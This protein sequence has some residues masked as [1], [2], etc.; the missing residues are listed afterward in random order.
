M[1]KEQTPCGFVTRIRNAMKVLRAYAAI[2]AGYAMKQK[3][4]ALPHP[5]KE[6][7]YWIFLELK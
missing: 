6:N 4:K 3:R 1:F 5:P 2:G 7:L